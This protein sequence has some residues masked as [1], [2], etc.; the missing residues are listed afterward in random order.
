MTA[1]LDMARGQLGLVWPNPAVGCVIWSEDRC[2]GRGA[3]QVGGRPHAE[4]VALEEAGA[5]ARGAT[6]YV[7]LEPCNH[8]GKT[9]PCVDALLAAGVAKV[10]VAIQDPDP[11]TNGKGIARLRAGGVDVIIGPQ[12]ASAAEINAGFFTRVQEGRPL[13]SA[14]KLTGNEDP[15]AVGHD[16]ILRLLEGDVAPVFEVRTGGVRARRWVVA[17]AGTTVFGGQPV[18]Y[19]PGAIQA[20]NLRSAMAAIGALGLTRVAVDE[21]DDL[22]WALA[23]AGLVDR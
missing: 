16:A 6:A 13:V 20:G 8:W 18:P 11:R 21:R 1:A 23:D 7:S 12:A 17:P 4:V 5:S 10:V 19:S 3:T 15:V 22:R 14:L 2:V 9:P